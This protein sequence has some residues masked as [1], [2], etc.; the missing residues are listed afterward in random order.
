MFWANPITDETLASP[1]RTLHMFWRYRFWYLDI[2]YQ[3]RQDLNALFQ[4]WALFFVVVFFFFLEGGGGAI[5]QQRPAD[6]YPDWLKYFW[7]LWASMQLLHRLRRNLTGSNISMSPIKF[8]FFKTI[9]WIS[10]KLG[11]WENA[12]SLYV[13]FR[14]FCHSV[15]SPRKNDLFGYV[16]NEKSYSLSCGRITNLAKKYNIFFYDGWHKESKGKILL[17]CFNELQNQSS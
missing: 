3:S 6:L 12:W 4:I 17:K 14:Y 15:K 1:L 11:R 10:M 13:L 8:D 16:T 2:C 7:R 9:W 5:R